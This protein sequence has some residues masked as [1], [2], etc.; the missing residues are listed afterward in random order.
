MHTRTPTSPTRPAIY[1]PISIS[2]PTDTS[3]SFSPPAKPFP[4]FSPRTGVSTSFIETGF[5]K[6][7][8]DQQIKEIFDKARSYLK[9][10]DENLSPSKPIS[11]SFSSLLKEDEQKSTL[12]ERA[13]VC[14]LSQ[15]RNNEDN[16][17]AASLEVLGKKLNLPIESLDTSLVCFS[18][19]DRRTQDLVKKS[20]EK[21]LKSK[22]SSESEGISPKVRHEINR[23][24]G[25]F[26]Q[27]QIRDNPTTSPTLP[28]LGKT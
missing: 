19:L 23:Y 12:L 15:F 8:S 7:T 3:C 22:K 18:R 6:Q 2:S 4:T 10:R 14:L 20:V 24:V 9:W 27:D 25:D 11:R 13:R 21:S 26:L 16:E 5:S 1:S 17:S 28:S